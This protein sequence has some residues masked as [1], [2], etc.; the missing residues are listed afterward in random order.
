[1]PVAVFYYA[2]PGVVEDDRVV[3]AE[4]DVLGPAT[5]PRLDVLDR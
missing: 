5:Q 1:V 2:M 3:L 4:P